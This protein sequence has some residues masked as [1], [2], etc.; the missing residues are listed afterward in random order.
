LKDTSTY[1]VVQ[2]IHMHGEKTVIKTGIDIITC[3]NV[4]GK[5][6]K[7]NIQALYNL[8]KIAISNHRYSYTTL[9]P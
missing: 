7:T 3:C 2:V 8:H 5:S 9:N 6:K 4:N 1:Y